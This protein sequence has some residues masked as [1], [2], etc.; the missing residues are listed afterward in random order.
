[1]ADT[2]SPSLARRVALGA[3]GLGR[4][5]PGAAGTRRLAAEIRRLGLLQIDSVNV[6]ERSHHL[7]MLAR[8]GPYD[9][10]ALDRMLFGGGDAYTEYWAHQAA[11]LPV[12]DLPLFAWRME[13]ERARRMPPGLVG[14]RAPAA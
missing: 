8:V 2:V 6:F 7:P 10:A 13:A 1:M 9:R 14:V 5:H 12:D 4:P 3:Q 11:V